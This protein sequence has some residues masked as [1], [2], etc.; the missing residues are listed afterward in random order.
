[1]ESNSKP[2]RVHCSERSAK[3]LQAQAPDIITS[4]RGEIHV[5]GKG[6]MVT[7]WVDNMPIDGMNK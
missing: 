1:M 3:L 7:Y 2:G 4:C 5:K 6:E